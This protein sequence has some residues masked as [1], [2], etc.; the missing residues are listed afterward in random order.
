MVS[1]F[2]GVCPQKCWGAKNTAVPGTGSPRG[3]ASLVISHS[4]RERRAHLDSAAQRHRMLSPC[5]FTA[6]AWNSNGTPRER[7]AGANTALI[8][9]L[10]SFSEARLVHGHPHPSLQPW[11]PLHP[12]AQA[13]LVSP[14]CAQPQSRPAR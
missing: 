4:R 13:R 12:R 5:L 7:L 6:P 1:G 14:G 8:T 11:G 9:V 3:R 2:L 10:N